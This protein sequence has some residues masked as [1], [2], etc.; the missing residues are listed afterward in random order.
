MTQGQLI[1]SQCTFPRLGWDA[2]AG[3]AVGM[4]VPRV[5]C[6]CEWTA[7]HLDLDA[8][9]TATRRAAAERGLR[10]HS[11]HLPKVRGDERRSASLARA[12]HA[13]DFAADT[14]MSAVYLRGERLADVVDAAGPVM[15]RAAARGVAVLVEPHDH[16]PV[17][18]LRS[19]IALRDLVGDDRL[20]FVLE[21][22][23]L[24][25]AGVPW[26]DFYDALRDDIRAVHLKNIAA[27]GAWAPWRSGVVDVPAVLDQLGHD[28][29]AG[30]LVLET[31]LGDD[32]ATAADLRDLLAHLRAEVP[33]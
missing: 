15:E 27:G 30:D 11:L 12:L 20:G 23:H 13:V 7:T 21:L 26:R 33:A 31:E 10:L 32:D 8:D 1:I 2:F 25:R 17:F 28:N 5:E 29:F 14:G 3:F 18:D 4:G 22:G 24:A 16:T 6:F 19:A 9:A